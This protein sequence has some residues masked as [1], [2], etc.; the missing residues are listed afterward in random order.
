[1]IPNWIYERFQLFA[2]PRLRF[3]AE[4]HEYHLDERQLTSW[5]T[6]IDYRSRLRDVIF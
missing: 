6:A 1:M 4:L 5:S 2:G 3:N